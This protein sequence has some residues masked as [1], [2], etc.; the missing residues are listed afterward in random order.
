MRTM[1]KK[2]LFYVYYLWP[3]V[4]FFMMYFGAMFIHF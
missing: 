4:L 1:K 2:I 3:V